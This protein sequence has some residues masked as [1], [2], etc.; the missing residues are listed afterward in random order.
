MGRATG[1]PLSPLLVN[2]A[3]PYCGSKFKAQSLEKHPRVRNF[4][5]AKGKGNSHRGVQYGLKLDNP[6]INLIFPLQFQ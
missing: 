2:Q 6:V 5:E 1:F 4:A 3:L